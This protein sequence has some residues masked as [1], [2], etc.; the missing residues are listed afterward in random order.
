MQTVWFA[1]TCD[2]LLERI[3]TWHERYAHGEVYATRQ[4]LSNRFEK[5]DIP[6]QFRHK[7]PFSISELKQLVRILKAEKPDWTLTKDFERLL[8]IVQN[9]TL[10]RQYSGMVTRR[11]DGL[12]DVFMVV[13]KRELAEL[14]EVLVAVRD[15]RKEITMDEH[16]A[17]MQRTGK[18]MWEG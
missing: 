7:V 5:L 3:K 14:Y 15:G 11:T 2:T 1:G 4:Y 9:P 12:F 18:G 8:E 16:V 6:V 13:E 17:S 10:T